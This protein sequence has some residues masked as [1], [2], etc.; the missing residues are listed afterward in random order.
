MGHA[1]LYFIELGIHKRGGDGVRCLDLFSGIG[2]GTNQAWRDWP[3]EPN[4][5]RVVNGL[6]DVLDSNG[7]VSTN[8]TPKEKAAGRQHRIKGLGNAV[9]PQIVEVIGNAIISVEARN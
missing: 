8:P 2:G 4:V 1:F 9:V 6:S 7:V 3:I 5:G